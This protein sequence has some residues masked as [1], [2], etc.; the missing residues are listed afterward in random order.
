MS[1]TAT[2][3]AWPSAF[4]V[5]LR[6]AR[7]SVVR[8][9]AAATAAATLGA[10]ATSG[11]PVTTVT[12]RT[13]ALRGDFVRVIVTAAPGAATRAAHVVEH[14]GGRIL[15]ELPVISGFDAV[16]PERLLHILAANRAVR[17]I[18]RDGRVRLNATPPDPTTWH[19]AA[20]YDPH[21]YAG[22]LYNVAR[23]VNADNMWGAG[24]AGKGVGVALI[25]SGVAP[26]PDMATNLVNGP[27]LSLDA[28]GT[29]ED[30]IDA[31]GH[32]THMAG[33][34]AGKDPSAPTDPKK[35]SGLKANVFLGIAPDASLINVKVAAYDGSV[36]VS[37]VIAAIGWVVENRNA[38]GMNIRVLNLSFGTDGVQDETLDPLA[39]AAEVA[40]SSGIVV[41]VS[42]G[43]NGFDHPQLN[44]PATNPF[45]IAAGAQDQYGTIGTSDDVVADFSSRGNL[46]RRP[47]LMAPGRSIV[48]L[49]DPGSY[50]D[51]AYPSSAVGSDEAKGSGTSQAAAVLSGAVAL[52]LQ[53]YPTLTPDQVKAVLAATGHPL[54][55]SAGVQLEVGMKTFD[56]G[57]VNS[58]VSDVLSGKVPSKQGF[59]H[60]NGRGSLDAARGSYHLVDPNNGTALQGE[61]DIT[62]GAWD[63]STWTAAALDGRTWSGTQWMGRTWSG[64][65][66]SGR[67]WSGRTWSG[68]T[69]TGD[70]WSGDGWS[71]N[72]WSGNGWAGNGWAGDA[73]AGD[74]WSSAD[75]DPNA[76]AGA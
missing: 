46:Q 10:L 40:W 56:L 76:S 2:V 67:T 36:D 47:D 65:T 9:V 60:A 11:T 45:V 53:R 15:H 5:R 33:I 54:K 52:V 34:I 22:S 31:F 48:S 1:A 43:N 38:A 7:P 23:E 25:D 35:Y 55:T 14:A 66:W 63:P 17:S 73:W 42:A 75:L 72:G 44:D 29:A 71:G 58:R 37:Q 59:A 57:A 70:A 24:Y 3:S 19:G 51:T 13:R 69:W 62:G 68:R 39:Y 27:D 30:G 20:P 50:I 12:A 6:S 26:V 21:A 8:I 28:L 18:T 49:R 32:G 61:V 64:R 16:V 4:A 41:V 74:S